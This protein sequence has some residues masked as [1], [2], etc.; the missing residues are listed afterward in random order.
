[1]ISAIYFY[2]WKVNDE[3]EF[4]GMVSLRQLSMGAK[5]GEC[6]E[7]HEQSEEYVAINAS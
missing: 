6:G 4:L 5:L 2:F 1:M 7:L 3:N